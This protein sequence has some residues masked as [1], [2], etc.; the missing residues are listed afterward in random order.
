MKS[1][2]REVAGSNLGVPLGLNFV[3]FNSIKLL[4]A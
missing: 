1:S 4:Y 3:K 2:S